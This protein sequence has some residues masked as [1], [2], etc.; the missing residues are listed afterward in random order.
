V[1][2]DQYEHEGYVYF[3]RCP[4]NG[5]IKVGYSWVSPNSRF[6]VIRVSSPVP[7]EKVAII[8]ASQVMER[9]Y[10]FRFDEFWDHAEW[11]RPNSGL[12]DLIREEGQDWE[13]VLR[14]DAELGLGLDEE[15]EVVVAVPPRPPRKV[16]KNP[17]PNLLT[18]AESQ[19]FMVGDKM[20]GKPRDRR[21]AEL[22]AKLD[23][24]IAEVASQRAA[25]KALPP[26][27]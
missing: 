2:E 7:V 13:E 21:F 4:L 1:A 26:S 17:E 10:H 11:F 3:V 9:D 23:A 15:V 19:R 24:R 25:A 14:E 8:R 20:A 27:P 18:D 16:A 12:A 5:M 6:E 22:H